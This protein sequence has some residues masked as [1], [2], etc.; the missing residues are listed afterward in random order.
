MIGYARNVKW[1]ALALLVAGCGAESSV[2]TSTAPNPRVAASVED[3]APS[4]N[5]PA[6][7][8][9]SA[10]FFNDAGSAGLND[11]AL[12]LAI[13]NLPPGSPQ[14]SDADAL[15][16][17][18][19][20]LLTSE[21]AID[22]AQIS[23]L[24]DRAAVD[25][26]TDANEIDIKDVAVVLG[27][28]VVAAEDEAELASSVNNLLPESRRLG[29]P[30]DILIFPGQG[31]PPTPTPTPT[32]SPTG[33]IQFQFPTEFEI[34]LAEVANRGGVVEIPLNVQNNFGGITQIDTELRF[35]TP[36]FES[37]L[38]IS[39]FGTILQ[40]RE[41]LL[42]QQ[43]SSNLAP[44]DGCGCVLLTT[45]NLPEAL[46]PIDGPFLKYSLRVAENAPIGEVPIS[47]TVTLNGGDL[48]AAATSGSVI[49]R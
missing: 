15:A 21:G 28:A 31:T 7:D 34:D 18:A 38:P 46:D 43:N 11:A 27:A 36:I 48:P 44:E 10:V 22:P 37:S 8:R 20:S 14:L 9:V 4:E 35:D 13:A 19:S 47:L 40:G 45:V 49:V 12:T 2:P 17:V 23:P 33:D 41:G 29:G 3:S 42:S 26:S 25:F 39:T 6:G 24:P 30:E 32:P 16:R 5:L 1:L